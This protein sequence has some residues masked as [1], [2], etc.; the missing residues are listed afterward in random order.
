[1]KDRSKISHLYK[2]FRKNIS[3][4]IVNQPSYYAFGKR[5]IYIF[6]RKLRHSRIFHYYLYKRNISDTPFCSCGQNKDVSF[7]FCIQKLL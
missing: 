4:E 3:V 7:L 5:F 1:M 6:N 2:S